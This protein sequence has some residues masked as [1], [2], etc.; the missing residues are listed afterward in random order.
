MQPDYFNLT[1][2]FLEKTP[3]FLLLLINSQP[4]ELLNRPEGEGKWTVIQVLQHLIKAEETNWIPRIKHILT[5]NSKPLPLFNRTVEEKN[6]QEKEVI[7]LIN[8]F[9]SKRQESLNFLKMQN[10]N[11]ELLKTQ[12]THPELGPITIENLLSAWVVHDLDHIVQICR[13]F[14]KSF[15]TEVGQFQK[16]LSILHDRE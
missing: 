1:I 9:S 8:E 5:D 16:F 14:A 13:I 15:K 11:D 4:A 6:I 2:Y 10:F 12:C 3:K 7:S